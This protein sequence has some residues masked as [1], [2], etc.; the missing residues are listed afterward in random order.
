MSSR[1]QAD[2][3]ELT[4]AGIFTHASIGK[5]DFHLTPDDVGDVDIK[6]Y[7]ET[8]TIV[9]EAE[10]SGDGATSTGVCLDLTAGEADALATQLSQVAE[11]LRGSDQEGA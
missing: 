4:A 10:A 2:Q 3:R 6:V 9:I 11:D 1:H 8:G 5:A 7:G